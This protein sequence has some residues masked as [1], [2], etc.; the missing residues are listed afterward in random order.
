MNNE[1]FN[2]IKGKTVAIVGPA[3]YMMKSNLGKEI[4]DHDI[5]VRINRSIEGCEKYSKDIGNRTDV[6][7]SCMIEKPENG[8]KVSVDFLKSKKIKFVCVPPNST[9]KG[10]AKNPSQISEYANYEKYSKIKKEIGARI[11]SSDLNNEVARNVNCRPNTGYLAIFD[12]LA[13]DPKKLSIYGF[14]FYL[15]GFVEGT[16]QGISSMTEAEYANKCFNS[17]RHVQGNLWK[18]AKE[19]LVQNKIVFLDNVLQKILSMDTFSKE[20]FRKVVN[21][22]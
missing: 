16:K 21:K 7:Y 17:K 18:Y 12:L 14:S 8:G 3:Q 20:D 19:S 1:Y 15:D 4:D 2:L 13:Q 11:I 9:M 5:V 10:I 6:L 22:E